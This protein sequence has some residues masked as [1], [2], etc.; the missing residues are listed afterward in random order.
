MIH[1]KI[2]EIHWICPGFLC[3]KKNE[4]G[5]ESNCKKRQCDI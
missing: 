1:I 4:G 5:K 2:P 3:N